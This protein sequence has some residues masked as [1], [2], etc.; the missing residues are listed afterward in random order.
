MLSGGGVARLGVGKNM[1]AD[2]GGWA[3]SKIVS[4]G[5][6]L[7]REHVIFFR[8][9]VSSSVRGLLWAADRQ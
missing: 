3:D 7:G 6:L 1:V 5:G 8:V 2:G 4:V 9:L